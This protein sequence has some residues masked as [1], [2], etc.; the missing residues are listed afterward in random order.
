MKKIK[1]VLQYLDDKRFRVNLHKL[2]FMQK[3]AGYLDYL[4]PTE[5]LKPYPQKIEARNTKQLKKFPGM[6]NS[7]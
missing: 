3:E 4:L 2:F 1:E 7:Y 5:S 6:V